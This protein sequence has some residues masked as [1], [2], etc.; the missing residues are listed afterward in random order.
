M[1]D[2][3]IDESIKPKLVPL[4]DVVPD[5]EKLKNLHQFFPGEVPEYDKLVDDIINRDYNFIGIWT[6]AC[7]LKSI[8]ERNQNFDA[9]TIIALLFSPELI[10]REEAARTLSISGKDVYN[11]VRSRLSKESGLYLEK[12]IDGQ[13]SENEFVLDKTV[14][15]SGCFP[16]IPID[17]LIF[18]A[19]EMAFVEDTGLS[20]QSLYKHA[21]LWKYT[22]GVKSY[23]VFVLNENPSVEFVENI[24]NADGKVFYILQYNVFENYLLLH[25][26]YSSVIFSYIDNTEK[27]QPK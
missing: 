16:E 7:A 3:V 9:N 11:S 23:E 5:T 10:L 24:K 18:L 21:I 12:I 27:K 14:F 8:R 6:K 2:I 22:P 1:I 20:V 25:P 15:L 4:V 17:D 13:I 19:E 26:D